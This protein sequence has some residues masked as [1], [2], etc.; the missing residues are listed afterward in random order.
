AL[1][2]DV[3][4]WKAEIPLIEEWYKKFG[5]K[6]PTGLHDELDALKHRLG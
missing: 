5:D 2:V 6:L 4:E 1:A 3:D